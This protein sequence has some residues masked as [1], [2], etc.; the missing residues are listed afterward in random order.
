MINCCSCKLNQSSTLVVI[1]IV[2]FTIITV[3]YERRRK[4]LRV[5]YFTGPSGLPVFGKVYHIKTNPA[6]QY[7][8]WSQRYGDV[9]QI[10]LREIPVLVVNSA[11]A[12]KAIFQG[13][14][15]ALSSRPTFFTFH[16]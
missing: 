14:S 7:G 9:F 6:E 12:A 8:Q 4:G 11:T 16:E 5:S 15:N 1:I 3:L 2:C 10:Q 13:H